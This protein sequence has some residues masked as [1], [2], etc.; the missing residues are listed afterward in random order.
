VMS[1]QLDS[2][3]TRQLAGT[4]DMSIVGFV[5]VDRRH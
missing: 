2:Q 4:N 3:T 1:R 5:P